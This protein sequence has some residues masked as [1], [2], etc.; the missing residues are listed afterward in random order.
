MGQINSWDLSL[1]IIDRNKNI[2]KLSQGEYITPIKLEE[3]YKQNPFVEDI[4]IYGES[5]KSFIIA[6]VSILKSNLDLIKKDIKDGEP[7]EIND[8]KI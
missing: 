5:T 8:P 2:F 3:L 6:I 7:L 4:F 1:K